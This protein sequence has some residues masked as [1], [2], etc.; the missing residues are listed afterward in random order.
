MA[1][2]TTDLPV[3]SDSKNSCGLPSSAHGGL[4]DKLINSQQQLTA[5]EQFSQQFDYPLNKPALEPKYRELI[6]LD[7]PGEDEQYSFEV[8]LDACSGCKAC[9]AACH[10]LNGLDDGELWRNVGMLVG[11]GEQDPVLQ[12]VTAS[13]H[14]CLEPACMHGC[15]V[16][17]YEKDPV[18]GIVAH[19]DDQCIGC[20][21]CMFMCP[22]DV[23]SYSE[24]K[25]IVRK[26]NMCADRLAVGEAPACVQACPHQAIK[27]R[28]V[29]R[30][31]TIDNS[32]TDQLVPGAPDV[33]LTMPT[34]RYNTNRVLPRNLLPD[35][36]YI[37]KS[38]HAHFPLVFMLTLTQMAFGI[39][40]T[41]FFANQLNADVGLESLFR[42]DIFG[43]L[44]LVAGLSVAILHL[45]RPFKAYRAM[46]GLRTSWLSREILGFNLFAGAATSLLAVGLMASPYLEGIVPESMQLSQNWLSNL[47]SISGLSTTVLGA[48]AV[49]AS[50]MLYIVTK[51]PL[52]SGFRTS[53]LFF[54]TAAILG[55]AGVVLGLIATALF[56]SESGSSASLVQLS[57]NLS[58]ALMVFV[59]IKLAIEGS[60]FSHFRSVRFTPHRHAVN[61]MLGEMRWPT[62]IR[63]SL[64]VVGG[65]FLPLM[66]IA[67]GSS[68]A[69]AIIGLTFLLVAELLERY[70]FFAVSVARRMPGA[71]N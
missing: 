68:F 38:L 65:L 36:Y 32:E 70:L 9:V 13:C 24:S 61:L 29:S 7:L 14:H 54:L 53:S 26:C 49:G 22:Y 5:V 50:A 67:A 62:I 4:I 63:Y 23:P 60:I 71:P 56:V 21:Y 2:S 42:I 58:K 18:T 66:F 35:D 40:A 20:K 34:T 16:N 47:Y 69:L 43:F 19:L 6:P 17:A 30:T 28:T 44:V 3:I 12:H 52:W 33:A 25:G 64:L 8:D 31:E 10:S 59:L 39:F 46:A 41:N 48:L 57:I 45:G 11:G 37:S 1:D 27:I 51:R 15:P 55:I